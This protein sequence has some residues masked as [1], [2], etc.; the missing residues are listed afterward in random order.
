MSATGELSW[1]PY[2]WINNNS[3]PSS[4][5]CRSDEAKNCNTAVGDPGGRGEILP[6]PFRHARLPLLPSPRNLRLQR[7]NSK[8]SHTESATYPP[9]HTFIFPYLCFNIPFGWTFMLKVLYCLLWHSSLFYVFLV[10]DS[11]E[12]ADISAARHLRVSFRFLLTYL[13]IITIICLVQS[14]RLK[15]NSE[16]F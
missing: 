4:A 9:Q 7:T 1:L 6:N 10:S 12:P 3:C 14:R 2:A 11:F 13:L 16:I 8:P 15:R 5:L